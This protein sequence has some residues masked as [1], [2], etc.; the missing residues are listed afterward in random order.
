MFEQAIAEQKIDEMIKKI[1]SMLDQQIDILNELDQDNLN[2]NSLASDERRIE[3]EYK[4]LQDVLNEAMG[5]SSQTSPST[6]EMLGELIDSKQN[7]E[8]QK[9]IQEAREAL[10][11]KE[12]E[13]SKKESK[14]AKENLEQMLSDAQKAKQNFEQETVNEMINEFLGVVNSILNISRFQDDLSLLSIFK[15]EFQEHQAFLFVGMN[16]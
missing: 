1:E 12:Q 14:E 10:S 11:K 4:N 16:D 8:T 3:E 2:Y 5:A 6:S 9:N 13:K 15:D 7:K